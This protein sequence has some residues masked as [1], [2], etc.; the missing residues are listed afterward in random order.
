[1]NIVLINLLPHREAK[2]KKRREAFYVGLVMSVLSAVVLLGVGFMGLS[3][4]IDH[5]Q[6]RNSFLKSQIAELDGQIKD[7]ATLRQEI[8]ALRA[9]QKAVEDLQSD[10]NMPVY[11]FDELTADTPAGVQI[12]SIKQEGESVLVEGT[13]LSQEHVAELLRTLST[14]QGWLTRPELIQIEAT[15]QAQSA[16]GPSTSTFQL[17]ASLKRPDGGASAASGAAPAA[18]GPKPAH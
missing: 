17:R 12:T 3:A 6:S 5:Q 15:P 18:S 8:D 2:R 9:R 11:L 4:M 7:I 16:H 13:A 14:S 1:M 10:R